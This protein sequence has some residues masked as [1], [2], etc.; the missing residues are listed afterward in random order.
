MWPDHKYIT[1]FTYAITLGIDVCNFPAIWAVLSIFLDI[2]SSELQ[3]VQCLQQVHDNY[4]QTHTQ[5]AMI[6]LEQ[7]AMKIW[8]TMYNSMTKHNFDRVSGADI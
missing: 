2:M 8:D 3:Y 1:L 5:D 4:Y 6:K 7:Q